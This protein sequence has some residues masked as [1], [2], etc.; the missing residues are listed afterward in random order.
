MNKKL[1][2]IIKN[3]NLNIFRLGIDYDKDCEFINSLYVKENMPVF[4]HSPYHVL[5]YLTFQ[6]KLYAIK[7]CF[8]KAIVVSDNNHFWLFTPMVKSFPKFEE[9]IFS[10][11]SNS[12]TRKVEIKN[13][14]EQWLENFREK[15]SKSLIK[16]TEVKER[17]KEEAIYDTDL[18]CE[19]PGKDFAK[20]RNKRNKLLN[21][22]TLVL[23]KV[24]KNNLNDALFVLKKWSETQGYKYS[25]NK[26]EKEVFVLKSFLEI[27]LKDRN[28]ILRTGYINH[29]PLSICAFHKVKNKPSWGIIYLI[30]GIN[31]PTDGGLHGVSD[32]TYCYCF[33][34]ARQ[35]G[36]K[37]LNDG[38]LGSEKGT[39]E[40]KLR[41]KPVMFLKSLDL[42]ISNT[43]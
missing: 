20:L 8:G 37:R 24:D 42:V 19:L 35:M 36:I 4:E 10:L 7:G 34:K 43:S 29:E 27:S 16:K 28:L 25:K 22:G 3:N 31:R 38:E 18:L 14:S 40:H 33:F 9:F 13:V 39:R 6:N 15:A 23:Q 1:K 32:A 26:Y 30:K 12:E 11:V 17:S 5:S 21:K 41:F 2:E